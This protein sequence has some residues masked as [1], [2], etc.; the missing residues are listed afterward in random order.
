MF[1]FGVDEC[2]CSVQATRADF[3][4]L[5]RNRD[6]VMNAG[7]DI[8]GFEPVTLEELIENNK[9]FKETHD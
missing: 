1:L 8:N 2:S 9:A 4:P 6:R 3:W 5:I 7:V